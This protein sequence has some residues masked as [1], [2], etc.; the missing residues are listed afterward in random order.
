MEVSSKKAE[1]CGQEL[2]ET[3]VSLSG[4]PDQLIRSELNEILDQAE[5]D[6]GALTLEQLRSAMIEY[7]EMI[8]DAVADGVEPIS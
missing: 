1:L 4:L 6:D 3:V 2:F 5:Q 7:L 8:N